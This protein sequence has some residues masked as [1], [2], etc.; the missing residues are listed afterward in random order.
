MLDILCLCC[1]CL[2]SFFRFRYAMSLHVRLFLFFFYLFSSCVSVFAAFERVFYLPSSTCRPIYCELMYRLRVDFC[3]VFENSMHIC[4][5]SFGLR[6]C[7]LELLALGLG[8][9][10]VD[11]VFLL[12][13]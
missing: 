11:V 1:N 4:S 10:V 7:A 2:D 8:I 12:S 3:F 9:G 6:V 13:C 5:L